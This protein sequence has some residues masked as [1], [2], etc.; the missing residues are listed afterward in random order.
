MSLEDEIV[1]LTQTVQLTRGSLNDATRMKAIKAAR[2]LLEA[3]ASPPETVIQDVVLNPVLLMALRVGVQI[4][5]FQAIRDH[6]GEGGATTQE[7]AEK[8]GA[9]PIVVGMCDP[10]STSICLRFRQLGNSRVLM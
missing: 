9:S 8:S 10:L 7:I 5:V 6:H 1:S 4:G 2:G 3:L